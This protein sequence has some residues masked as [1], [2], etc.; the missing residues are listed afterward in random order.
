MIVRLLI[1][2]TTLGSLS[3][4]LVFG[5]LSPTRLTTSAFTRPNHAPCQPIRPEEGIRKDVALMGQQN[6]ADE[7]LG[8]IS[9]SSYISRLVC[10]NLAGFQD[11][12]SGG[13]IG[14]R[15]GPGMVVVSGETGSG[16]S[17]LIGKLVGLAAGG[18]RQHKLIPNVGES[19]SVEMGK[20]V[21]KHAFPRRAFFV[22]WWNKY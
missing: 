22:L 18:P 17:L 9:S 13:E 15:L 2:V 12:E 21:S 7:Q 8:T 10:Y 16:K 14:F 5:Y 4:C 1:R 11:A 6:D 3:I 20:F 19:F